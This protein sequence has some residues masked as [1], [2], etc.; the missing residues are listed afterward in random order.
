MTIAFSAVPPI[1]KPSIPGGHQPAPICGTVSTTQS[2]MLSEG[3]N[4]TNLDLIH[5]LL[6]LLKTLAY[7]QESRQSVLRRGCYLLYSF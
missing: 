6:P 5:L 3:F 4:I 1:P 7:S 2:T